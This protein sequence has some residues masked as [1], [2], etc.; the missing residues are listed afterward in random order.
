MSIIL[1]DFGC[2]YGRVGKFF[3][4][5]FNCLFYGLEINKKCVWQKSSLEAIS[6]MQAN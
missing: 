4:R 5:K 1:V 2:G 6:V 3:M